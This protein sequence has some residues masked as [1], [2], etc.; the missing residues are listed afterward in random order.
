M[1]TP[2]QSSIGGGELYWSQPLER[3][4]PEGGDDA[5]LD[6]P[7]VAEPGGGPDSGWAHRRQPLLHQEPGDALLGRLNQRAG[8][9]R[10]KGLIQGLLTLL[11]GPEAALLYCRRLPVTGSGTSKYQ[12]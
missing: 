9:Q 6:V 5:P 2:K 4:M 12:V 8:P 7:L 3:E 1:P 10:R 11:L